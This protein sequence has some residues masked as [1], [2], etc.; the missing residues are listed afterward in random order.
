MEHL[1]YRVAITFI[2]L[3]AMYSHMKKTGRKKL[4][5]KVTNLRGILF[6]IAGI[7]CLI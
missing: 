2:I 7:S 4:L 1:E 3:V 5:A 6:H